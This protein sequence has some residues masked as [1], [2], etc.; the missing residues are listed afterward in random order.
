MDESRLKDHV[1]V[2]VKNCETVVRILV[3]KSC[4]TDSDVSLVHAYLA[5]RYV[6]SYFVTS[7]RSGSTLR[8]ISFR[9]R[10]AHFDADRFGYLLISL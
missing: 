3:P 1:S 4:V 9:L 6:V 2:S 10:D 5:A 7:V 8:L